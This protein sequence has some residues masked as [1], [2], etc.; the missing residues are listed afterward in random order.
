[1]PPKQW[2]NRS[3]AA[4]DLMKKMLTYDPQ[5]RISAEDAL[6]HKWFHEKV[7]HKVDEK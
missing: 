7:S 3:K 4:I 5:K 6:K 2:S 1:M